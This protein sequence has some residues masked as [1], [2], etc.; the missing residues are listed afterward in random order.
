MQNNAPMI[1]QDN[2]A[3]NQPPPPEQVIYNTTPPSAA[4]GYAPAPP[5]N[6]LSVVSLVLSCVSVIFFITAPVGLI[7]G[8]I[9]LKQINKTN[10]QGKGM[11]IAG[12]IVGSFISLILLCYLAFI[13]FVIFASM[14]S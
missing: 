5:T 14:P 8:I 10:E 3:P 13:L 1:D 2:Q 6:A 7:L 12:I 9:S 4:H 11:A